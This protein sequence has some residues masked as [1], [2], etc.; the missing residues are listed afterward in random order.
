M[1]NPKTRQDASLCLGAHYV[2]SPITWQDTCMLRVS[3]RSWL[4]IFSLSKWQ[5]NFHYLMFSSF[6]WRRCM[7][8]CEYAACLFFLFLSLSSESF[9]DLPLIFLLDWV[10]RFVTICFRLSSNS[11]T[12]VHLGVLDVR[13]IYTLLNAQPHP[14]PNVCELAPSNPLFSSHECFW[15]QRVLRFRF[16]KFTVQSCMLPRANIYVNFQPVLEVTL[17]Y[18]SI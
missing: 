12:G 3:R 8:D 18:F 6:E 11:I 13:F 17:L 10:S 5:R 9:F 2:Q 4:L 15:G 14:P 16:E 1:Q 7:E